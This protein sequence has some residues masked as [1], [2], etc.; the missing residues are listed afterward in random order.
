MKHDSVESTQIEG[1]QRYD[2]GLPPAALAIRPAAPMTTVAWYSFKG[3]VG[4]TM[5]LANVC[6]L[7]ARDGYRVGVLDLDLEA[8]GL[9]TIPPFRVEADTRL[10]VLGYLTDLVNKRC[11]VQDIE[12]Y[13]RHLEVGAAGETFFL[14]AGPS[15]PEEHVSRLAAIREAGIFSQASAEGPYF[16]DQIKHWFQAE[17]NAH[18]LLIDSRTGFSDMGGASTVLLGDIVILATGLN[19]NN[20]DSLRTPLRLFDKLRPEEDFRKRV[21]GL[22]TVASSGETEWSFR[23]RQE[24][25]ELLAECAETI[26]VPPWTGA[27]FRAG[28]VVAE[29]WAP[30]ALKS[31]YLRLTESIHALSAELT[32]KA[33]PVTAEPSETERRIAAARALM[34]EVPQDP[35]AHCGLG[36]LLCKTDQKAEGLAELR[37]AVELAPGN[38]FVLEKLASHLASEDQVAEANKVYRRLWDLTERQPA[39]P[40][41][42]AIAARAAFYGFLAAQESGDKQEGFRRAREQCET[43][44]ERFFPGVQSKDDIPVGAEDTYAEVKR[45]LARCSDL[46]GDEEAAATEFAATVDMF[47]KSWV[48]FQDYVTFLNRNSRGDEL[49]NL[50]ADAVARGF[51]PAKTLPL[52]ITILLQNKKGRHALDLLQSLMT[53]QGRSGLIVFL[54]GKVFSALGLP[55]QAASLLREATQLDPSLR[56]AWAELAE[57]LWSMDRNEEAVE[58]A[59]V[60]MDRFQGDHFGR[61]LRAEALVDLGRYRDAITDVKAVLDAGQENIPFLSR[62]AK[63]AEESGEI[64]LAEKCYKL[65]LKREDLERQLKASVLAKY[66]YFVV[67][68]G[69]DRDE[70]AVQMLDEARGLAPEMDAVLASISLVDLYRAK[71]LADDQLAGLR[72]PELVDLARRDGK[73][74]LVGKDTGLWGTLERIKDCDRGEQ[75]TRWIAGATLAKSLLNAGQYDRGRALITELT[76]MGVPSDC[77]SVMTD[78]QLTLYGM[79]QTRESGGEVQAKPDG[80]SSNGVLA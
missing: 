62:A 11:R 71:S 19:E 78:L 63:A 13:G 10:G 67:K 65:L 69:A 37:R 43:V 24:A 33:E 4:R 58:A 5:G 47:P 22:V 57:R 7:L 16:L 52:Y 50:L 25:A 32:E 49:E 45:T 8:P 38:V 40:A 54:T 56:D 15:D 74:Q 77:E 21:I 70:Q 6:S 76:R 48:V 79:D 59:T 26:Y 55:K 66:A 68:H 1:E 39:T 36:E 30:D 41:N 29:P 34:G 23:A 3:G 20:L 73:A 2:A 28:A 75:V 18:Y 31:A 60:L 53:E 64:E 17:F 12:Q 44:I 27:A 42:R 72:L 9:H 80:Q 35:L 61:L 46:L 51:E 14:R